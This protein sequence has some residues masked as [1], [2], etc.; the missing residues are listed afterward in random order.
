MR[1]QISWLPA[2]DERGGERDVRQYN[3]YRREASETTAR[4]I[5]SLPPNPDAA[6][7][8]YVD[9][10]LEAGKTYVYVLGATDCTPTA[11]DVAESA[12]ITIPN[13]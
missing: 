2:L 13:A 4:P 6:G 12:P 10:D 7:Y 11:S 9:A 8:S 1:V 3:L 5:A